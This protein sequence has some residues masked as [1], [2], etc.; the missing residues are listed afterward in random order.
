MGI[1]PNNHRL[2]HSFPR[3]GNPCTAATAT[4]SG[5]DKHASP[6]V[7]SVGDNDQK[8]DSESC[9][10]DNRRALPDLNLDLSI[11]IPRPSLDINEEG[12]KSHNESTVS[13]ELESGPPST[14]ILFG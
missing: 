1:D 9:L 5:L 12:K 2:S 11:T 10:V 13:R 14:L 7:R 6:Q 8:S 4:P 3:L